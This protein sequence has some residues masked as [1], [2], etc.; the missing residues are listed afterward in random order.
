MTT[1]YTVDITDKGLHYNS[2]ITY[3][4]MHTIN[5]NINNIK[6]NTRPTTTDIKTTGTPL[7]IC[8]STIQK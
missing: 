7:L 4:I 1:F 8:C 5:R 6:P 3:H 2:N